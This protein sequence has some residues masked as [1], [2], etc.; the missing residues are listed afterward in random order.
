MN[1][2][3]HNMCRLPGSDGT[4]MI[5]KGG[6][7]TITKTL[8]EAARKAG[9]EILTGK[10]VSS[11]NVQ[12]GVT[13]GVTLADGSQLHAK[14]VVV[15]A[16]PF[17]LQGFAGESR[18]AHGFLGRVAARGVRQNLQRRIEM[19]EKRFAAVIQRDATNGDC[20][21]LSPGRLMGGFH[22]IVASVFPG[23]DDE[24]RVEC[25]SGDF[26]FIFQCWCCCGH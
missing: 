21:H 20:H 23:A 4:W 12:G 25:F 2:L 10:K 15:N 5:V 13:T 11:I 14:A 1:F 3:V 19:I 16:D 17:R 24:P 22:F 6:M 9:A 7:G 8:A 18:R 26:K